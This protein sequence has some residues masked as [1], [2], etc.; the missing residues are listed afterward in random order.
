ME[1]MKLE[2]NL[3]LKPHTF[4][5]ALPLLLSLPGTLFPL[6]YAWQLPYF[7]QVSV[8]MPPHLR[9]LH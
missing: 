4:L 7:M 9:S 6:L 3:L 8:Q 5:R 1:V 2:P